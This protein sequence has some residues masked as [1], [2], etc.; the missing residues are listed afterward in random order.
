MVSDIALIYSVNYLFFSLSVHFI[1]VEVYGILHRDISIN[2]IL[3]FICDTAWTATSHDRQERESHHCEQEIS[4][5]SSLIS[6]MPIFSMGGSKGY[7]VVTA[8]WVLLSD[9]PICSYLT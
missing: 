9:L 8:Q 6:I 3:V 1:L 5:G 4:T 7:Q 2:N